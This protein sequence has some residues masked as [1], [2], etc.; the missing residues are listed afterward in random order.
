MAKANSG[1]YAPS[2]AARLAR[3][4]LAEVHAWRREGIVVP[5][6]RST[7]GEWAEQ[8]GY[9]FEAV[10]YLRLLRMLRE[11]RVPLHRS[12]T[13][14]KHLQE[15]FG[16]PGAGWEAARIF[17]R[18]QEAFV[19]SRDQWETTV[20]SKGG[21]K[22]AEALFDEE[23]RLLRQRADALLVPAKFQKVVEVD[24]GVRS[25]LPTIRGTTLPTR[26]LHR[27]RSAGATIARIRECYPW[28]SAEQVK[29]AL[30][31]EQYLDA[32]AM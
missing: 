16:P 28:L 23:F 21:Q 6:L 1:F 14:V 31:F 22:V 29:G 11:R 15:R 5:T 8:A 7:G 32:R 4:P 24:P 10:V 12:V 25:G 18:G 27:M 2:E 3:V 19:D 9:T 30:A 13:A 26:I 20:A 17:V